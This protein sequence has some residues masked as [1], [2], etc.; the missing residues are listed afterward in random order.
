M[1]DVQEPRTIVAD[2]GR[3]LEDFTVGDVYE[4]RPGRTITEADNI[5]FSLL[6]MNRHPMHCD[7]AFAE[8]SEFGKPLVNSGL[9]LAIVLGM[10]VDDVSYKSVANLGWKEIKLVAPVFPGDTVYARSKVLDVRESK[11]RPTQGIVT[12][13]TEGYKADGTVFVTFERASLVPKRG[14]GIGD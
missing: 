14:H 7:H 9:T 6:T 4:H 12:T 1:P 5:Q 2:L 13:Y 11:K 10:T 8:K 3:Y